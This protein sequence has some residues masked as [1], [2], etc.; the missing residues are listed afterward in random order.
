M[1]ASSDDET[2]IAPEVEVLLWERTCYLQ[3]ISRLTS[4]CLYMKVVVGSI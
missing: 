3:P 4:K 1:R 2:S